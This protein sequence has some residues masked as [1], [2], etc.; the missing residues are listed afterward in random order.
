MRALRPLALAAL[1][2]AAALG[3]ARPAGAVAAPVTW[4]GTDEVSANRVPDLEVSSAHQIR[5]IYAIPADGT[6]NFAADA[7]PIATDVGAIDAWWQG[8]D[9]TRTPRFDLYPFSGCTTTFG[10]L[11]LAFVRL[12]RVGADYLSPSGV[13]LDLLA[14]DVGTLVPS[15]V[16]GLV[17]YDGP[18]VDPE[19]CGTSFTNP[20]SGGGLGLSF[21]YL[22]AS[23]YS[24]L[25]T[26]GGLARVTAHEL[27][28]NLGAVPSAAPN[29]CP[30]PDDGH[31][32]DTKDD[33][34]YPYTYDGETLDT[35]V[36]DVNHDDYYDHSG[37]WWDVR[38]SPWLA[39][40]PQV[41]LTVTVAGRGKVAGVPGAPLCSARCTATL[42]NGLAVRLL[43]RPATGSMFLGWKGACKGTQACTVAMSA[44]TS[45]T[46]RFGPKPKPKKR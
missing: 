36:L 31:V 22:Q 46:A 24:D 2:G 5:V 18:I 14:V 40:L 10:D 16:K 37:S 27:I 41:P 12:P 44:A 1:L 29:D 17:Y 4:C 35:A 43:A 34:M 21:V 30:P 38:N 13:N 3:F 7:S 20:L 9:P 8:Q 26:G 42:D 15:A 19:V 32:C 6:D 25:G 23:C 28:H 45:A 39:H 33:I 11:D